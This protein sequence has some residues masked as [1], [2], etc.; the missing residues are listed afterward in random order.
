MNVPAHW[1]QIT[2]PNETE[3]G[4]CG[5]PDAPDCIAV[6]EYEDAQYYTAD[7]DESD[8]GPESEFL[9]RH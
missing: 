9:R 7:A 8:R 6:M 2:C 1:S 3:D 5:C 4:E